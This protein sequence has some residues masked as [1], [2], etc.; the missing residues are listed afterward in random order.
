MKN[1]LIVGLVCLVAALAYG[2]EPVQGL[3]NETANRG[4]LRG[5]ERC[6]DY[7]KSALLSQDAVKVSCVQ[8]F[9]ERL[10][11]PDLATGLARPR[12]EEGQVGWEGSLENKTIDHVTTWVRISV[13]IYDADGKEQESFAETPIWIDPMGEAEFKVALPD[14]KPDQLEKIEFCDID[15]DAPKACMSWGITDLKG[16]AI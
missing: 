4:T 5:A 15:D 6:M 9:Q 1:Y 10:Y 3:I 7:A 2:V 12:V 14:L 11:L 13:F 16:L 8:A